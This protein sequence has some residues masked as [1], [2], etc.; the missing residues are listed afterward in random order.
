MEFSGE[1]NYHKEAGLL[2]LIR[3]IVPI[4]QGNIQQA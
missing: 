1:V 2:C 3:G 4:N